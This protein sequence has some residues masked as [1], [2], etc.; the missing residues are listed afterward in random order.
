MWPVYETEDWIS[1]HLTPIRHHLDSVPP[2]N[3]T[4]I[5]EKISGIFD[6]STSSMLP[7]SGDI[8]KTDTI[9]EVSIQNFQWKYTRIEFTN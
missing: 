6:I 4:G 9:S 3:Y 7:E 5:D 1:K 8:S 2:Y